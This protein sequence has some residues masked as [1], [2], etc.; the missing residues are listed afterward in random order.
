L[1][2]SDRAINILKIVGRGRWVGE[3]GIRSEGEDE[4]EEESREGMLFEVK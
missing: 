3:G 4:A 1:P 2:Y